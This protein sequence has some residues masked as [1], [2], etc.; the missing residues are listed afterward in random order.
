VQLPF[1]TQ[2]QLRA[3]RNDRRC[4]RWARLG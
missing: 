1:G 2:Q 3:A 4:R